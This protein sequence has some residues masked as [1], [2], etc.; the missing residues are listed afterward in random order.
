MTT[1]IESLDDLLCK[2]ETEANFIIEEDYEAPLPLNSL[3]QRLSAYITEREREAYKQGYEQALS[4][5]QLVKSKD[6]LTSLS[7]QEDSV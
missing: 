4:D 3:K 7:T 1:P 2:W 5:T 6:R